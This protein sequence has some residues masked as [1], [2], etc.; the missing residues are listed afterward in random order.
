MGH[1][2]WALKTQCP[3]KKPGTKGHKGP[4][5]PPTETLRTGNRGGRKQV[6][7]CQGLLG[8]GVKSD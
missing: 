1:H 8:W 4:T 6:R 3:V 7:G 5:P 2:E